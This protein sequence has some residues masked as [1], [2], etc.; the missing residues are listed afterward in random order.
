MKNNNINLNSAMEAI[1]MMRPYL[2]QLNKALMAI[3]RDYKIDKDTRVELELLYM[4]LNG[5]ELLDIIEEVIENA[6]VEE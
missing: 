1:R 3:D 2:E 6:K 5:V 4:E